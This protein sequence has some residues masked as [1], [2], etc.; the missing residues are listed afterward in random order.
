MA[1][2]TEKPTG[3]AEQ[4]KNIPV[5]TPKVDKKNIPKAPVQTP[6]EEKKVDEKKVEAKDEKKETKKPV[7]KIKKNEVSVNATSVPVSTKYAVSICK[8]IKGKRIR[9]AIDDL[10]KVTKLRK[11]VPMKG[12]IPHRKGK[13][14]SGRFPV[15]ASKEFINLLKGLIGNANNHEL[16]NPRIT[17]AMANKAAR[18]YGRFGRYQRKRT[19][20]T[21]KAKEMKVKIKEKPKV[22]ENKVEEKK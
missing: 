6:K 4:K 2:N 9:D 19:H 5:A 15:R 20:V 10:E 17:E 21:I 7:K 14:M 11:A 16:E 13:M 12:E 8:F 18:P 1:T 3:K 22:K